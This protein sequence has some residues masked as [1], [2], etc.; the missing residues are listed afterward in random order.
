MSSPYLSAIILH[1]LRM[2]VVNGALLECDQAGAP[3]EQ[4]PWAAVSTS[5]RWIL[6]TTV[7]NK[8]GA[9]GKI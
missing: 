1:S 7:K 3:V 5:G 6:G 2:D 9:G 4:L 8:D